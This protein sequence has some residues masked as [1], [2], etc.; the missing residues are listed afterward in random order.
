LTEASTNDEEVGQV[1]PANRNHALLFIS[2]TR[3]LYKDRRALY[4]PRDP[5][6]VEPHMLLINL[7]R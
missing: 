5:W 7:Q 6:R 4:L 1:T 2:Q 3:T